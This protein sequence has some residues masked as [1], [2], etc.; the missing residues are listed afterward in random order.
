MI[1]QQ[2]SEALSPEQESIRELNRH[3]I[4]SLRYSLGLKVLLYF[5]L[6]SPEPVTGILAYAW[7]FSEFIVFVYACYAVFQPGRFRR[8][9]ITTL[10]LSGPGA[11]LFVR[12]FM[13]WHYV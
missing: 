10:I 6:F 13:P 5:V 3:A 9:A 11:L 4:R 8:D 7:M 2:E 12:C 1:D